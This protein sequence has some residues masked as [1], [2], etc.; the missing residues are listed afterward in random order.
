MSRT[1]EQLGEEY[2]A[3]A[4]EVEQRAR[5]LEEQLDMET[6]ETVKYKLRGRINTMHSI[7]CQ[8][9]YTGAKLIHYYDKPDSS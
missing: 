9:R 8:L 1:I 7:V 6:S 3:N 5:E 2:L 4:A